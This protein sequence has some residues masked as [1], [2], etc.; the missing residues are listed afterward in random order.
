MLFFKYSICSIVRDFIITIIFDHVLH[1]YS[2][3]GKRGISALISLHSKLDRYGKVSHLYFTFYF[4]LFL[5]VQ[6]YHIALFMRKNTNPPPAAS[7]MLATVVLDEEES[8]DSA[9]GIDDE[10]VSAS[11]TVAGISTEGPIQSP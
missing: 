4:F 5:F 3:P 9:A 6:S 7:P 8:L 2:L 1:T 11:A 10:G